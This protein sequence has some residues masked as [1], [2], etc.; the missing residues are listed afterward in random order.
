MS[1]FLKSSIGKKVVMALSGL[2]LVVFLLVHL[3]VNLTL[4]VGPE[5]F[6]AAA[7]FMGSNPIIQ[8]MQ[9]V[10][11][12]GFLV[13]IIL[14]IVF[15]LQNRSKT[16]IQ[17][18]ESVRAHASSFASR[19][20]LPL[21]IAILGFLVFHMKFFYEMKFGTYSAPDSNHYELVANVLSQPVPAI[22]YIVAF[23][24][25]G[26]HLDHGFQSAFQTV[27]LNGSTWRSR[28]ALVGRLYTVVVAVGFSAI[29]L[30]FLLGFG[31]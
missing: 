27:G 22:A 28:M 12:L 11:A 24:A 9:P 20:M 17:Y 18:A 13:H 7:H 29:A 1:S 5:A 4:L 6:N 14:G 19:Y 8:L 10:L 23:V 2:F 25:L 30:F 31:K 15:D 26:L 16:P 21:G 3:V